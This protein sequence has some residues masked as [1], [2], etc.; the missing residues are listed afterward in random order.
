MLYTPV[1]ITNDHK[2]NKFVAA[3]NILRRRKAK[4]KNQIAAIKSKKPNAEK[5]IKLRAELYDLNYKINQSINNQHQQRQNI[6]VE[7]IKSNPRY[8]YSFA[9][10]HNKLRSTV[11]P[12]LN[13]DGDLIHDPEL[14][15]NIL[16]QQYSSVFSD[17]NS[18]AKCDPK[19]NINLNSILETFT[20]TKKDII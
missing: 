9:R 17:P 11:G 12:L 20:F 5:L 16:Q 14:M 18:S 13:K 3:R 4:V 10:E 6:A 15:A 8:F 7:R 2:R 1:K 19:I